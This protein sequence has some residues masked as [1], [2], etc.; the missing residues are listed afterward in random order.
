VPRVRPE[1]DSRAIRR[2]FRTLLATGV[3][4]RPAGTAREDPRI[5]LRPPYLPRHAIRL[6]DAVYYLSDLFVDP[7]WEGTLRFFV[8]YVHPR[9]ESREIYPRLFEKDF[10]L[11]WRSPS[12]FIRSEHENW[13]GKGDVRWAREG[14]EE[15]LYSCEETTNLPLEIQS[16]LD[17]LA[18]RS[19]RP[20]RDLRAVGRILRH[21]PDHRMAPYED[22]AAPRR[23]ARA[24]ARHRI[25]GGRNIA[26][27]TRKDDPSSLRFAAGYE[28][29]FRRGIV[30]RAHTKSRFYGG[31]VR[32][33]RVLSR[34]RRI[35]FL[36]VA[37]PKV[38]WIIPPQ[39]LTTEITSYGVRA[40]DVHADDDLCVPGFEYHFLDATVAP[41]ELHSQIPEGFAGAPSDLDPA[42]V[43]AS[44]WCEALPVI[45][46]F[47]REVL[48]QGRQRPRRK[49][50][51]SRRSS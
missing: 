48:G 18:S 9:C 10:S 49:R 31:T 42:R 40:I 22:F 39:A 13:M 20:R 2:E 47:R 6:F 26:W 1:S 35:Q 41:P 23:R 24:K 37:A 15:V 29:D 28:P 7:S 46:R 45:R 8:A 4:L 36:F 32:K 17:E 5:F 50:G 12:H 25:H 19:P 30:E 16:A 34:N 43:D 11:V 51:R 3:R 38:A 44:A 27:F 14:G 33:F 21:A